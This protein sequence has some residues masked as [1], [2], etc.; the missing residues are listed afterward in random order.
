MN[1]LKPER[2]QIVVNRSRLIAEAKQAAIDMADNGYTQPNQRTDIKV[3][4][5]AGIATFK[6]GIASMKM[7]GY[8]T[9]HDALIANKL[10]YVI[11]GGDLSYPQLVSEQYLLDL[12][13][14]AFLSLCG[15]RKTL[16]RMQG[17][18]SGGKPP[19]N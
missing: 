15:E 18:L 19:R 9:E 1:Y 11:C 5:R 10:A 17:L 3:Q 8:I 13:L 14:E 4:G 6:A 16:E 7:A 12:E 2:D